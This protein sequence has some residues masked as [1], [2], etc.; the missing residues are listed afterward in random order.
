MSRPRDSQRSKVYQAELEFEAALDGRNPT[1][2]DI[3][4]VRVGVEWIVESRWWRSRFPGITNVLVQDGRGRR[5]PGGRPPL[6]GSPIGGITLPRSCRH[7]SILLHELAHIVA[8]IDD[9]WHGKSF[10]RCYLAL[11]DEWIGQMEGLALR[12]FFAKNRVKWDEPA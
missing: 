6:E 10:V 12:W 5:Y 9:A 7:K 2:P 4:A 8:P 11:V 1:Y 3:H